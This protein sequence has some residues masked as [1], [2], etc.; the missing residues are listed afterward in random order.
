MV[1]KVFNQLLSAGMKNHASDLHFKTGSPPLFRI[2]GEIREV[3]A[4]K[5]S[6]EDVQ[7]IVKHIMQGQELQ[8]GLDSL[9]DHDSSYNLEGVGRFRVNIFRQKGC[10]A[11]IM[12]LIPLE[13]PGFDELGLP[14]VVKQIASKERGMILVTGI[15]GSGKS[16]TLASMIDYINRN[17]RKHILTIE[18]PIEFMHH[19]QKSSISQREIGLDAKNFV[20]SLRQALRQDPDVILVGEM[21]DHETV[22]IALKAA[23]TGHLVFST[24]HTTDAARTINRIV[25]MFPSEEQNLVRLRLVEA[26]QAIISQRLLPRKDGKGRAL[27][28][29]VMIN[30]M[31]I[32]ECIKE[33]A[34]TPQMNEYIEKGTDQYGMQSFDQSLTKLYKAGEISLEMAKSAASNPADF[35]RALYVD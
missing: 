8:E 28:A 30:T 26:L 17:K 18:D 11:V 34:K 29:E 32:A 1:I 12:R 7:E 15:T 9:Q 5:L 16:S 3:K 22:D 31:S 24:V 2:N 21:R 6:H 23:E 20:G 33:A 19:D 35:E 27:A 4:P 14:P 13:I 25:G 10:L